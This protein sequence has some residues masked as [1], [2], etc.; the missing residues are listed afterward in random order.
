MPILCCSV[1]CG[2][3]SGITLI[4]TSFPPAPTVLMWAG[5][6]G[7][8]PQMMQGFCLICWSR[9]LFTIRRFFKNILWLYH[10]RCV[11]GLFGTIPSPVCCADYRL[12]VV[13]RFLFISLRHCFGCHPQD[14]LPGKKHPL[15]SLSTV[16]CIMPA[17]FISPITPTVLNASPS[18]Q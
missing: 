4:S 1:W 17:W 13:R 14:A 8:W 7:L 18:L 15:S 16:I 6:H 2:R 11:P 10:T 12:F 3:Q 5:S 9:S